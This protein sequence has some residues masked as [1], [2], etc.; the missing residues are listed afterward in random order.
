MQIWWTVLYSILCFLGFIAG[1]LVPDG[2][3][4]GDLKIID[5]GKV[6]LDYA[7]EVSSMVQ[8]LTLSLMGASAALA[9]KG[10]DWSNHW[11]FFDAAL[12]V[13]SFFGGVLALYGI[14]SAHVATIS[15]I[16]QGVF[17]PFQRRFAFA[18]KI[19]YYGLLGGAY[20]L[21]LVFTRM[22]AARKTDNA[23]KVPAVA[24]QDLSA[25]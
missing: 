23:V 13:L 11:T 5:A 6:A 17:D 21:G 10:K 25:P 16:V 3:A 22:L 4:S 1:Y 19:E 2:V 14:Y 18:L 24:M 9:V 7:K 15:M 20:A 12:V 8:T